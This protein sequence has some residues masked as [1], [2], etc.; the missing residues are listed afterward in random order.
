MINNKILLE[1]L[2]ESDNIIG[3]I[4]YQFLENAIEVKDKTRFSLIDFPAIF[5]QIN[6]TKK[7]KIQN[8][9][10]YNLLS[11]TLYRTNKLII[12]N[13][14]FELFKSEIDHFS[15]FQVLKAPNEFKSSI[16]HDFYLLSQSFHLDKY[17]IKFPE[18]FKI[19]IDYFKFLINYKLFNDLEICENINMELKSFESQILDYMD[20]V[21][22]KDKLKTFLPSDVKLEDCNV[23]EGIIEDIEKSKKDIKQIIS[24]NEKLTRFGILPQLYEFKVNALI[25][26]TFFIIGSYLIYYQRNKDVNKVNYIN[27]LWNHIYPVK[28]DVGYIIANI[29]VSFDASWLIRIYLYGLKGEEV[30][31]DFPWYEFDDFHSSKQ[32][33]VQYFL[34]CITKSENFDIFPN[35]DHLTKLNLNKKILF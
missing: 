5:L 8:Y 19:K 34:L 1:Q 6:H 3:T 24:G 35:L 25:Y 21:K 26:R 27:E 20:E 15:T 30:W 13:N 18:E 2:I 14:D 7:D 16:E 32:Y 4:Y 23:Y 10:L 29:P 28:Q 17:I 9:A 12:D 31:M 33:M 22:E 11:P